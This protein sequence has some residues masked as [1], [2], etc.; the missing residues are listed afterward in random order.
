MLLP[1]I[2]FKKYKSGDIFI[3]PGD[4]NTKVF[5]IKSGIICVYHLLEN[6]TEK[7]MLFHNKKSFVG[8]YG[9]I[10]FKRPS[11]FFY[12]AVGETEVFELTYD[13]IDKG[14]QKSISLNN[15]RG[16]MFL[17]M[18]GILLNNIEDFVLLKPEERYQ[19]HL[20]ENA[21]VLQKVPS[22][23]I[24]SLLGIT[25]VSLSRIKKRIFKGN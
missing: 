7:T 15:L 22:K 14:A 9:G 20:E 11:R 5:Y 10:I 13:A 23:Y 3:S 8:N 25:P 21:Q 12:Q 18:I 4:N 24:A 16:N 1:S 6:G 2:S 19:K 17:M